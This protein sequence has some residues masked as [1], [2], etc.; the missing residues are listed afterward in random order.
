[1]ATKLTK[2]ATLSAAPNIRVPATAVV[3][4]AFLSGAMTSLSAF[5]IPVLLDTNTTPDTGLLLRQWARLYHYGHIYLPGL[6]IATCALYGLA[7]TLRT[8]KTE[9]QRSSRYILAAASTLSMV[10][11]T[12][13]VMVP[14]NDTLFSLEAAA[15]SSSSE[16]APLG[17]VRGLLVRWAWLHVARSLAPLFG[18]YLG[19]TALLGEIRG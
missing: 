18:V 3:S 2:A 5:V 15:A 7:A 14:T 10:P 8:R 17:I 11:F 9:T 4:G 12:W 1:M 19:F 6:C 13:L 16:P